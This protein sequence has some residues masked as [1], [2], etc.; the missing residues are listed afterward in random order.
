VRGRI[1][2]L[3][4][5]GILNA[6]KEN[7]FGF[8]THVVSSSSMLFQISMLPPLI[9]LRFNGL[10]VAK[11]RRSLGNCSHEVEP[12]LNPL[13]FLLTDV[14]VGFS[15]HDFEDLVPFLL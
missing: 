15:R 2:Y 1:V 6:D 14:G 5:G 11:L 7:T 3:T 10:K 12:F 9:I 8:F 4:P 13:Q